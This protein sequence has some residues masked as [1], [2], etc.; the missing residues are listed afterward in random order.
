MRLQQAIKLYLEHLQ[1]TG[2]ADGTIEQ[3]HSTLRSLMRAAGN[4]DTATLAS[5]HVAK[6]FNS[7]KWGAGTR[8]NHLSNLRLFI[9]WCKFRSFMPERANPLFGYT[10]LEY[11]T[12][13]RMQIP[14]HEWSRLFNC[15]NTQIETITIATGL[16]LFLRGSE[17]QLIQLRHV[18]LMQNEI[19][20][21]RKKNKKWDVMPVTAELS[22]FMRDHLVWLAEQGATDSEH[23]LI[24][25]LTPPQTQKGV[26]G[27][28]PNSRR[29][30]PTKSFSRPYEIVQKVLKRA[31]YPTFNEGEHTLRRSGARAYFDT[32]V[33]SGY[34]GALRRVQSMLGHKHSDMTERYLGLDLDRVQRNKALS[35]AF[36]FPDMQDAK[37]VAFERTRRG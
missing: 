11:S 30:I 13:P 3:R 4:I 10:K 22:S 17:Q 29:I 26:R 36:M 6:L 25:A 21:Y 33:A 18:H 9:E 19:E 14:A 24:P 16:F 37:I 27:F 31:G 23:Y 35:G 1:A 34:D 28:I 12:P 8:N 5:E 20:I 32:L 2:L 15:C 7:N